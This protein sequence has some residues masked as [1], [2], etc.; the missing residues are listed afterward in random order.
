MDAI[1]VAEAYIWAK[2]Q[3]FAL[4]VVMVMTGSDLLHGV[5]LAKAMA[6][7]RKKLDALVSPDHAGNYQ[8]EAKALKEN[9]T[10]LHTWEGA[11]IKRVV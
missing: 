4:G 11:L 10:Y 9:K 6:D 8:D 2:G 3:H 7:A 5:T 1:K